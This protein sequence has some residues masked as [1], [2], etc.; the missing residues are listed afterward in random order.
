MKTKKKRHARRVRVRVIRDALLCLLVMVL[1]V[2][3]LEAIAMF[4]RADVLLITTESRLNGSFN[5]VDA[6]VDDLDDSIAASQ[7]LL[8][9]IRGTTEQIKKSAEQQLGHQEAI[10][11]RTSDTMLRVELLVRH[12]DEQLSEI[13]GSTQKA[14]HSVGELAEAARG[15]VNANSAEASR[16]LAAMNDGIQTLNSRLADSRVDHLM[17][18][19]DKSG[20]QLAI[21]NTNVAEAAQEIRDRLSPK[22]VSFWHKVL[23]VGVRALTFEAWSLIN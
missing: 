2:A 22:K 4:H 11:R 13:S 5:K 19:L 14:T 3:I 18:S 15:A 16:S 10:W 21:A 9:S 17:D 8:V 23:D 1:C 12:A 20:E 7:A 6:A